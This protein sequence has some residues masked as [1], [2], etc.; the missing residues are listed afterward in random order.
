[1]KKTL[2]TLLAVAFI[3]K[4]VSA[5]DTLKINY[6]E[7]YPMC[8]KTPSGELKGIEVEI[9]GEYIKWMKEK[10]GISFVVSYR[11]DSNFDSLYSYVKKSSTNVIGLGM[12][13][14]TDDRKKEVVFSPAYMK[15][16]SVLVTN[17]NTSSISNNI[18]GKKTLSK[19]NCL[20]VKNST[21]SKYAIE[22][23]KQI[24]TLK[25]NN[26]TD[27]QLLLKEIN[28]NKI[29]FGYVDI[30]SFWY[31]VSKNQHYIKFQKQFNKENEFFGYFFPKNFKYES[32]LKEFFESGF[33]FTSTKTYHQILENHLG[34]EIIDLI[35][36]K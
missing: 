29:N 25:I 32:T 19:M 3:T 5:Q 24:P 30:I 31:Y 20:T 15:N 33:G 12:A 22:L 1:M 28:S 14:I 16:V 10:K 36:V 17:G 23:Q 7:N 2:T 21:H 4:F 6:Q 11:N 13:T 34:Y 26:V 27:Q 8:Y 9:L 35:E 18:E